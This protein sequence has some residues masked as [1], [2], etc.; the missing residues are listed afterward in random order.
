MRKDGKKKGTVTGINMNEGE[1]ER[2]RT[3]K[4]DGYEEGKN[5]KETKEEWGKE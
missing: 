2:K 3:G 1:K 5:R 4:K